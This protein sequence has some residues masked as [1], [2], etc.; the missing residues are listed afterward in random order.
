MRY[1][2]IILTL[3]LT[4]SCK[5]KAQKNDLKIVCNESTKNDSDY[6]DVVIIKSCEFKNHSF[7]SIGTPDY[8]GRYSYDYELFSND[9]DDTLKVNNSDFF[10]LNAKELEKL[11][12]D[13]LKAEFESNSKIPEISDCMSWIDFRYYK[14]NEFGISFTYKNQM[15]F[16]IDYGI[17]SACFNVS[18][19]SVIMEISKL[20]K[21][22]K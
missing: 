9:K 8:K 6:S 2:L 17:G 15:E 5:V 16:N 14:L 10:N 11:I 20:E 19:S 1:T 13:K 4:F 18:S 22:L 12:N 3:I 21:Y 7:K